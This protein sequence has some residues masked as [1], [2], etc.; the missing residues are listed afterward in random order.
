MQ[1]PQSIAHTSTGIY[2]T[3]DVT[4]RRNDVWP[5]CRPGDLPGSRPSAPGHHTVTCFTV[6][7]FPVPES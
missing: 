2:A 6:T 4:V 7:C 1:N 5:E 3:G